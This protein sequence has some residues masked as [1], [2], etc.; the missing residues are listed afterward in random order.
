M[1]LFICRWQLSKEVDPLAHLYFGRR[2]PPLRTVP[3]WMYSW[4]SGLSW[5]HAT[6]FCCFCHMSCIRWVFRRGT[7]IVSLPV[8]PSN[9]DSNS[10]MR[11][12]VSFSPRVVLLQWSAISL[13][14][15]LWR[16]ST[17]DGSDMLSCNI[18]YRFAAFSC[19]MSSES[20]T[21]IHWLR[22][23]MNSAY[24]WCES[25]VQPTRQAPH[26]V[27]DIHSDNQI[28][29]VLGHNNPVED[30]LWLLPLTFLAH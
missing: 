10:V 19:S 9:A 21:K 7:P 29:P 14:E 17:S 16:T 8:S 18:S 2:I 5:I 23:D 15:I 12:M 3:V 25:V 28:R 6:C 22:R 20:Q 1:N 27:P 13:L 30:L 4:N 11:A 26:E 24:S